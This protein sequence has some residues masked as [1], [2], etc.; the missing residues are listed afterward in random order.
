MKKSNSSFITNQKTITMYVYPTDLIKIDQA[1]QMV[2][3]QPGTVYNLV[4]KWHIP[5][6]KQGREIWFSISELQEFIEERKPKK[7]HD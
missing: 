2:N 3:L 7:L 5:F 6:I 4:S 1:S